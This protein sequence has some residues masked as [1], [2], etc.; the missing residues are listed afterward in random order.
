MIRWAAFCHEV[1]ET[2]EPERLAC[3][4][5]VKT[6]PEPALASLNSSV[7]S[8]FVAFGDEP[9]SKILSPENN[10]TH[11]T[12]RAGAK[13]IGRRRSIFTWMLFLIVPFPI[14]AEQCP[15]A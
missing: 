4:Q 5:R 14:P 1:F 15:D 3:L 2:S 12:A 7:G 6:A 10:I 11:G 13:T 9:S 8:I